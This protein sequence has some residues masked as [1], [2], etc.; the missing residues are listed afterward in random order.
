MADR[1][2]VSGTDTFSANKVD[3]YSNIVDHWNYNNRDNISN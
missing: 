3:M 2:E 1:Q